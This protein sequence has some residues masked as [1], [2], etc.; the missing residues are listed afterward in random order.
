MK[1]T[2]KPIE[3]NIDNPINLFEEHRLKIS[4]AIVHAI[5]YGLDSRKRK[6]EFAKVIV[7]E[8]ICITLAIN[9]AEFEGLLDEHLKILVEYEDYETCALIMKLK[10]KINKKN[11]KVIKKNRILD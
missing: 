1:D 5:D 2:Y 9:K 7:K 3:I 10:E 8:L 6:I 11:E 4:Q